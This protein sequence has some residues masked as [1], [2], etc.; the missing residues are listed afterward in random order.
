VGARPDLSRLQHLPQSL[1]G[2]APVVAVGL[3]VV[4]LAAHRRHEHEDGARLAAFALPWV[5]LPPVALWLAGQAT[6]LFTER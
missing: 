3:V 2:P 4:A 5:L 6:P 1:L